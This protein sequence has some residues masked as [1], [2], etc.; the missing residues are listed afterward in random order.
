[1]PNP[2]PTTSSTNSSPVAENPPPSPLS[3]LTTGKAL[4]EEP[5]NDIESYAPPPIPEKLTTGDDLVRSTLSPVSS[6]PNSPFEGRPRSP[7]VL[8]KA[9]P[10][11]VP[12]LDENGNIVDHPD[13]PRPSGE[14]RDLDEED[15]D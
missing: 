4:N 7:R 12:L 2:E 15:G 6:R 9:L 10:I 5:A 13:S 3:V 14:G 8:E 11:P 1:M